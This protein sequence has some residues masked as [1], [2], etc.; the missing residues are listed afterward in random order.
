[1]RRKPRRKEDRCRTVRTSDDTDRAGLGRGES[2]ME[3]NYICTED[4]YLCGSSDEH[5]P[6]L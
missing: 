5:E 1:M 3:R 6:R 2:H 4:S